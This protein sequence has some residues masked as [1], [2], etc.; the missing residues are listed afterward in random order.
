MAWHGT[1]RHMRVRV[2]RSVH[3]GCKGGIPEPP[4]TCQCCTS[5]SRRSISQRS[6]FKRVPSLIL[7]HPTG[8]VYGIHSQALHEPAYRVLVDLGIAIVDETTIAMSN[9]GSIVVLDPATAAESN[10]GR[11][12][13]VTTTFHFLALTSVG[14]RLYVRLGMVKAAGRDDWTMVASGVSWATLLSG[15]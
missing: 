15:G 6:A 8:S 11:I 13:A 7:N 2:S 5:H 4:P 9:S 12:L 1:A 14:L 3:L 10:V